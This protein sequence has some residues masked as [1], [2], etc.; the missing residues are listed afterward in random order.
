MARSFTVPAQT[1]A[2][3]RDN[4]DDNI[5]ILVQSAEEAALAEE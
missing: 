5:E 2:V 4:E 1:V 3:G